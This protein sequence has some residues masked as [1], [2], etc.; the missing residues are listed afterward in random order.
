MMTNLQ[1]SAFVA[2]TTQLLSTV[3]R[4]RLLLVM[5]LTLTVSAEVWADYTITFKTNGN[6][7]GSGAQTNI[8]NLIY[9]GGEYVSTI[10]ASK[11]YNGKDGFGVKLGSSSSVGYVTM[12]LTNSGSNIGQ[13]KASKLIVNAAYFKSGPTLKVTAT[14]SDNTTS[15]QSLSLTDKIAAYDV[16][17]SS[18]KTLKSIK[19]ESVKDSSECR[20]Y[21]QSIKVVAAAATTTYTVTYDL[22]GGTGTTPTQ[23]NVAAG[24]TFTLAASSG[25]SKAGY[26]FAGWNDGTTTY[27]AGSTYTMPAMDVTLTAQ[28]TPLAQHTVTWKVNN[29]V[30]TAGSP[31]TQV[32]NGDKVTTLPTAPDPV[33]NCG[34]VFV[35]WTTTP[36]DGTTTTKPSVLFTTAVNSPAITDNTTFY[37]VFATTSGGDGEITTTKTETFENQTSYSS[38]S[39]WK[40][41]LTWSASESKIGVEWTTYYGKILASDDY[42]ELRTYSDGVM[43]YIWTSQKLKGI[44]SIQFNGWCVNST[45]KADMVVSYSTDNETWNELGTHI[46]GTT[47]TSQSIIYTLPDYGVDKEYYISIDLQNATCPNNSNKKYRIDNIAFTF[48]EGSGTT[49]SD[50]TTSCS[51][52]TLVSVLPKIMNFWQSIFGVSLG[53]LRDKT[54]YR[55][56]LGGIVVVSLHHKCTKIDFHHINMSRTAFVGLCLFVWQTTERFFVSRGQ[57]ND[58]CPRGDYFISTNTSAAT[59]CASDS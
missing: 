10:S 17:L 55:H 8:A 29:T 24:G 49:Y 7:D 40:Q 16:A 28:W 22:N 36:I 14:Y 6:T 12:T 32:Y 38:E 37:A 57:V 52:E 9:S 44:K 21:C 39:N 56:V 46:A 47:S 42:V 45:D 59:F 20:A 26:S 19:I 31:T 54:G 33:N 23:A 35:G 3:A 30:Y 51:T 11:A 43:G 27:D 53:Y 1:S 41:A 34:E 13:I 58:Q 50:Y 4:L 2:K 25:F 5:L 18:T 15:I 48:V